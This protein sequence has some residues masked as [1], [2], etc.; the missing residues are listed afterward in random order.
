MKHDER[1]LSEAERELVARS[2]HPSVTTLAS[3][4]LVDVIGRLREARDQARELATFRKKELPGQV[5]LPGSVGRKTES[6]SYSAKRTLLSSAL[7][8]VNKEL[9]R[10]RAKKD[11]KLS[12]AAV[13]VKK[14]HER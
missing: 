6:H 5:Q 9:G 1:L 8:R 4:E 2:R 13:R 14:Q 7:K 11:G 3:T 10:R 12:L